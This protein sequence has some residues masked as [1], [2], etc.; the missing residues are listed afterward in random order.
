M[1]GPQMADDDMLDR[2]RSV[3]RQ[4]RRIKRMAE[5]CEPGAERD[6]ITRDVRAVLTAWLAFIERVRDALRFGMPRDEMQAMLTRELR[7]VNTT[8]TKAQIFLTAI[9]PKTWA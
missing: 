4:L 5:R 9:G 7:Q 8:I 3:G 6:Q 1:T 2:I